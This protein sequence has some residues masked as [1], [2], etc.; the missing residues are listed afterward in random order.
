MSVYIRPKGSS[1]PVINTGKAK[2]DLEKPTINYALTLEDF[3]FDSLDD[4]ENKAILDAAKVSKNAVVMFSVEGSELANA[5]A[6]YYEA[7]TVKE[8]T[9]PA[10]KGIKFKHHL[11]LYSHAAL[12]TYE[13]SEYTRIIEFTEDGRLKLVNEN[14]KFKGQKMSNFIVPMR[15][16]AVI[17]GDIPTTTVEVAYKDY[18]QFEKDGVLVNPNYDLEDQEGIYNLIM[19][20]KSASATEIKVT[21]TNYDGNAVE[22]LVLA[23]FKLLKADNTVQTITGASYID[24]EYVL[25]GTL[26]VTGTLNTEGVVSQTNIM[27]EGEAPVIVT[28]V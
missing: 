20:V 11:D 28:V 7:R 22:N 2:Q 6:T 23:D 14:G 13:G 24:G 1:T 25:T 18:N 10:R 4:A 16:D 5:E 12:R 19:V 21:V 3:E 9:K 27:Y 15:S 17:G 26:L 8:E